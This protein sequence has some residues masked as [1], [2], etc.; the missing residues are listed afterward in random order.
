MTATASNKKDAGKRPQTP[1]SNPS[2]APLAVEKNSRVYK[3]EPEVPSPPTVASGSGQ[4]RPQSNSDQE[5]EE[6]EEDKK[7]SL[8]EYDDYVREAEAL[9]EVDENEA[10]IVS[11]LEASQVEAVEQISFPVRARTRMPKTPS[12][13]STFLICFEA[14]QALLIGYPLQD[15]TLS[16]P[17]SR[18]INFPARP[19]TITVMVSVCH[20]YHI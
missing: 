2:I 15:Q 11:P 7:V 8:Q 12:K 10:E 16:V 18:P 9:M 14:S 5:A 4:Q 17:Q 3:S 20:A 6:E 13:T 19:N 1:S